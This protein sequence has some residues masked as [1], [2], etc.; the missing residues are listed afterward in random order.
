MESTYEP[1]KLPINTEDRA[2]LEEMLEGNEYHKITM[3]DVEKFWD[4]AE[5]DC[6]R[7]EIP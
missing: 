7:K 1:R 4:L 6:H 2:K 5:K 3:P